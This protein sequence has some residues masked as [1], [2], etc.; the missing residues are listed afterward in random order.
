M[1][2]N[3]DERIC[4]TGELNCTQYEG[5]VW[6]EGRWGNMD[7][8]RGTPQE[9]CELEDGAWDWETET[10]YGSWEELEIV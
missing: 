8:Y 7:C 6:Q 9:D 10:C 2:W 5:G 3:S 1:Y 4:I